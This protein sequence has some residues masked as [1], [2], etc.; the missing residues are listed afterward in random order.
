MVG[1]AVAGVLITAVG[2][3]WAFA[4][5]R[6]VLPRRDHR[7]DADAPG[8]AATVVRGRAASKGQVREGLPVRRRRPDLLWTIVL[9]FFIGT[10][11]YNFA[12]ILSAYANN[13]FESG[14]DLFGLLNTAMAIGSVAGALLAARRQT[15]RLATLFAAAAVFGVLLVAARRHPVVQRLR[16]P[17]GDHRAGRPSRST[18]WP[19]PPCSSAATP[20]CGAG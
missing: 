13:V 8:G 12:I 11:G 5:Q 6:A 20:N 10:F 15:T 9:V 17:A 2:S 16:R 7:P 19:T 14:A 1:P 4:R 18:P 3:A